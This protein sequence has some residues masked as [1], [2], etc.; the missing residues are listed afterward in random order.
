MLTDTANWKDG[1]LTLAGWYSLSVQMVQ[2]L[3]FSPNR[4]CNIL[5]FTY[6]QQYSITDIGSEDCK[7]LE[8]IYGG[9]KNYLKQLSV[10]L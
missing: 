7:I 3:H 6:E 2:F 1:T 8:E 5:Y 10:M 4:V 9:L